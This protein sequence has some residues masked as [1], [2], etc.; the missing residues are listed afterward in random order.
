MQVHTCTTDG[1]AQVPTCA[2][3]ADAVAKNVGRDVQTF[4]G[5]LMPGHPP[6][7][8]V[9]RLLVDTLTKACLGWRSQPFGSAG[10][11]RASPRVGT[12]LTSARS[13]RLTIDFNANISALRAFRPAAVIEIDVDGFRPSNDFVTFINFASSRTRR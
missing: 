12:L 11:S 1:D 3:H 4:R 10:R 9:N 5:T 8:G 7:A 2:F 6:R 13:T